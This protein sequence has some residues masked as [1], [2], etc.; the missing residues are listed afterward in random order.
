MRNSRNLEPRIGR[1]VPVYQ[2]KAVHPLSVDAAVTPPDVEAT[3]WALFVTIGDYWQLPDDP[4]PYRLRFRTFLANRVDVNPLYTAY[5]ASAN[6]IINELTATIGS[7]RAFQTIFTAKS[8]QSPAGPPTT[9]LEITQQFVANEFI[10]FRLSLGSFKAFG[11]VNYCGYMGGA[12]IPGEPVPY[13]TMES[14]HAS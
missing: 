11:A 10:A 1:E 2:S 3:L 5:Y 13:R 6:K 14:G 8:H 9:E 7:T 12:N 4:L